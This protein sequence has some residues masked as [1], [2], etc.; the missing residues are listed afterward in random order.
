MEPNSGA[1]EGQHD[2][3]DVARGGPRRSR[4]GRRAAGEME[5]GDGDLVVA[6]PR[7]GGREEGR[8]PRK[9]RLTTNFLTM[10]TLEAEK[11]SS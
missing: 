7:R 5:A 6:D 8:R 10:A 3:G 4:G 11:R 1:V 9:W 2:G